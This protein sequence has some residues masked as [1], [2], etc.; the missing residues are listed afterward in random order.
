MSHQREVAIHR[1]VLAG[2]VLQP[3]SRLARSQREMLRC[4]DEPEDGRQCCRLKGRAGA[5]AEHD[6]GGFDDDVL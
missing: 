1:D 6:A 3:G 5:S 2:A 4:D